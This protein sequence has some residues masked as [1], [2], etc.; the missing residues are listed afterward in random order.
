MARVEVPTPPTPEEV[1]KRLGQLVATLIRI[2]PPHVAA[3]VIKKTTDEIH[4]A[5]DE[6]LRTMAEEIEKG[7]PRS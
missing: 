2:A 6:V 5:M 1:G 4:A 3:R 7:P